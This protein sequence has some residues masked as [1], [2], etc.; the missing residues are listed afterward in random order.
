VAR[1]LRDHPTRGQ[2]N[3]GP[4]YDRRLPVLLPFGPTQSKC[5]H[6]STR[7]TT[8]VFISRP[9]W[10]NSFPHVDENIQVKLCA[11]DWKQACLLQ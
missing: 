3:V 7:Q 5:G 1:S 9:A 6:V 2:F 11:V 10:P 8:G 4:F